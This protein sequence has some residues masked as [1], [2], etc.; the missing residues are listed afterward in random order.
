MD[1]SVISWHFWDICDTFHCD[2]FRDSEQCINLAS[3]SPVFTYVHL[4]SQTAWCQCSLPLCQTTHSLTP[5]HTCE[6]KAY[7]IVFSEVSVQLFLAL[8]ALHNVNCFLMLYHHVFW[9]MPVSDLCLFGRSIFFLITDNLGY[10]EIFLCWGFNQ[11]CVHEMWY[12]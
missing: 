7:T 5:S 3:P 12:F 9:S 10:Y 6:C 11:F 2:F 4:N 1:I 8:F